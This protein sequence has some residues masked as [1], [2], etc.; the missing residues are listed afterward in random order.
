LLLAGHRWVSAGTSSPA[1]AYPT[2]EE[3]TLVKAGSVAFPAI[4]GVASPRA[5]SA[6]ARS[7]NPLLGGEGAAGA[8]LPLLVPEVDEDGNE[9]AGIRLP[10]VAVPLGTYTGWNFRLPAIGSPGEIVSL[11]GSSIPFPPTRAARTA[12]KDPRRSIEER[13]TSRDEYL[14]KV[15]AAGE[16]LVRQGYLLFDDLDRIVQRAQD[17]WDTVARPSS[18]N[19]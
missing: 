10:D 15:R 17:T 3:R 19:P 2:L 13:Y 4:P 7:A 11:L 12:S 9:R 18:S 16:A 5:I 1:S 8:P 6:G 14:S